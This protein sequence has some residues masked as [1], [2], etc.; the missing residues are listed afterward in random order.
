MGLRRA[1][2]DIWPIFYRQKAAV[3]QRAADRLQRGLHLERL[4]E[5]PGRR[6]GRHA[7]LQ[8][9]EDPLAHLVQAVRVEF[10]VVLYEPS[11]DVL[12]GWEGRRDSSAVPASPGV[13]FDVQTVASSSILAAAH[14]AR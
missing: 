11:L 2:R 9:V 14:D 8:A 13:A 5:R 10:G 3:G 4:R 12:T 7:E 1:R 6:L